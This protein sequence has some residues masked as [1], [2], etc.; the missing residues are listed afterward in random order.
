MMVRR[1]TPCALVGA[2]LTACAVGP[3]PVAPELDIPTAYEGAPDNPVETRPEDLSWWKGFNDEALITLVEEVRA[4]NLDIAIARENLER[5]RAL[6]TAARS[7]LFPTIDGEAQGQAVRQS[8]E[9]TDSTVS[10]AGVMAFEP[11]LFGRSRRR[12]TAALARLD[13]AAGDTADA[14]RVAVRT[15]A[16]QYTDLRRAGARLALLDSSLDLQTHT[17]DIVTSRYDAGL[18]P[19][20]DVDRA[21]ADLAQTRARRPILMADRQQAE[22]SLSVLSGRPPQTGRFGRPDDDIIPDFERG[23][24]IGF[25][26]DLLRQ[27]PDIRAAEARLVAELAAIGAEKADLYPSLRLPGRISSSSDAE[28]FDFD[29]V[30]MS[31]SAIVDIPLF[32]MGRR[33]AEVTAQ[34]RQAAAAALTWERQVLE[35]LQE[36]ETAFVSIEALSARLV[37]L[38][39]AVESSESAYRQL[40]ALYREGLA[41]F[42]DVLDAQR[43]LISTRESMVEAQADYASAIIDLY[44]GLG[45]N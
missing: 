20:L 10:L 27:R 44:S 33:R 30:T 25:P 38:E 32:D 21:A 43:T 34:E 15:A 3:E 18:S 17:L 40:D 22:F 42:I 7:D 2:M 35:A 41:S 45:V 11:D 12:L 5:S 23:P 1:W 16:Q 19:E 4:N 13:A 6:V 36:V 37:D 31:L 8:D 9:T 24:E 29:G 39:R 14:Q 26:A 28:D